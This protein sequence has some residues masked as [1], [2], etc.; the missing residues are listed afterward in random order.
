MTV[1]EIK[2]KVGDICRKYDVKRLELFGSVARG[3]THPASDTDFLVQ[4]AENEWKGS[5]WR[6]LELKE[7]LERVVG[8]QVDLVSVES[9][10]NPILKRAILRDKVAVYE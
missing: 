7:D 5:C 1:N 9:L 2:Q 8:T 4:F 3:D 6:F 10:Q